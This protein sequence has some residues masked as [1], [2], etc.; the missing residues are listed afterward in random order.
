MSS[1]SS[2]RVVRRCLV[3]LCAGVMLPACSLLPAARDTPAITGWSS[4]GT[5]QT[6]ATAPASATA[7]PNTIAPDR[8]MSSELAAP[9]A[10]A[11]ATGPSAASAIA[12]D[13]AEIRACRELAQTRMTDAAW[14]QSLHLDEGELR[15][16]Y[17]HTYD[18]CLHWHKI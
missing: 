8:V 15:Q 10:T 6:E 12:A 17:A 14:T 4:N 1:R 7:T 13:P 18:N 5:P 2:A 16:V 3:S 9:T 11:S